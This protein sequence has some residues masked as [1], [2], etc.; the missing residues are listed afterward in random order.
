[1][2]AAAH[3]GNAVLLAVYDLVSDVRRAVTWTRLRPRAE[4]PSSDHHSFAEHEAILA[5]I[6][7]RQPAQAAAAMRLHLASVERRLNGE[8]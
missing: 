5:S 6:T 4:G 8:D 2:S 3:S 1:M 7:Q